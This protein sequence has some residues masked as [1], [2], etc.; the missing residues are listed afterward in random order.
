MAAG[1]PVPVGDIS[2]W[3]GAGTM[4]RAPVGTCVTEVEGDVEARDVTGAGLVVTGAWLSSPKVAWFLRVA[5]R[6]DDDVRVSS[7]SIRARAFAVGI[8]ILVPVLDAI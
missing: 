2:S 7:C 6:P 5:L 3:S 8:L 1:A 4:D